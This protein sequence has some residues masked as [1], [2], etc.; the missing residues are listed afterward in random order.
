M[1][2]F[3]EFSIL[4][5]D[6]LILYYIS[7]CGKIDSKNKDLKEKLTINLLQCVITSAHLKE[8]LTPYAPQGLGE[9]DRR[10]H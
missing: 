2:I 9:T 3:N 5:S 10:R 7:I 8:M 1:F 6:Q 4:L